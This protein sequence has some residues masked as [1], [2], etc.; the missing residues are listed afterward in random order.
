MRIASRFGSS[1]CLA[2]N[3]HT[4]TRPTCLTLPAPLPGVPLTIV[5]APTAVILD[6]Y[7][8]LTGGGP[9]SARSR[10]L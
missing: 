9:S 2:R 3:I 8:L 6:S 4:N 1:P 7:P 5:L 10:F